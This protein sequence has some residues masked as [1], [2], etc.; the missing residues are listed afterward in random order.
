LDN[1]MQ[2]WRQAGYEVEQGLSGV[3]TPPNDVLAMGVE[4][5]WADA[6][7]YLRWEEELGHKYQP[8]QA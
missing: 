4:R 6:I 5:N 3:M 2:A 8:R 1:G 7:Q